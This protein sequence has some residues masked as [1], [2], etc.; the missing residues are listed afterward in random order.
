MP[1]FGTAG[2]DYWLGGNGHNSAFG[3]EGDDTLAG[4]GGDDTLFGGPGND[5]LAGGVGEVEPYLR[6]ALTRDLAL[7]R[8]FFDHGPAALRRLRRRH[9]LP[10]G[11][12]ARAMIETLVRAE[13]TAAIGVIAP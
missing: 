13:V 3:F 1:Y 11:P 5:E 2:N 6:T 8:G 10:A 12:V 7:A 4:L 9:G